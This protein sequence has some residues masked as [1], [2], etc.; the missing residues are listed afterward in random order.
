MSEHD[1]QWL[2][3]DSIIRAAASGDAIAVNQILQHYDRY[4]NKIAT[5]TFYDEYGNAYLGIDEDMKQMIQT[6]LISRIVAFDP[7]ANAHSK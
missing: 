7:D 1:N 5:R 4:I 2:I 3:P 6:K